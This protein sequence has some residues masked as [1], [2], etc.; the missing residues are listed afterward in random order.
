MKL[1]LS[2]FI[3]IFMALFA[4]FSFYLVIQ[5]K[6]KNKELEEKA[7]EKK[8]NNAEKESMESGNNSVDFNTSINLLHKRSQ[9]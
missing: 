7:Y 1:L 8:K 9:K 4:I 2:V 3:S 6:K 5:E